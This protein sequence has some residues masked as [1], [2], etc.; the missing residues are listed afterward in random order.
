[1]E[2]DEMRA[3]M[4]DGTIM[5]NKPVEQ[6]VPIFYV[7]NSVFSST[8]WDI[9]IDMSQLLSLTSTADDPPTVEGRVIRRVTVVMNPKY[10]RSF[11]KA[12]TI[13][14]ERHEVVDTESEKQP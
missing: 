7:N 4:P 9:R 12:L 13:Q 14:V 11:L 5:I 3:Q 10:A 8:Q 1:M 2:H 6:D